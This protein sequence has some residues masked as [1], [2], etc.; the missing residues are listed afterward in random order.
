[1]EIV[2]KLNH[3]KFCYISNH[4]PSEKLLK[5]V[6]AFPKL[7]M[8]TLHGKMDD[9]L[10]KLLASKSSTSNPLKGLMLRPFS[11]FSIDAVE[12]FF[13]RATFVHK[14]SIVLKINATLSEVEEMFK[15]IDKFEVILLEQEETEVKMKLKKLDE[16]IFITFATL[17]NL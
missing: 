6:D 14:S 10:L 7:P 17:L 11:G 5:F 12:R 4:L 15:R 3:L 16:E 13:K 9:E 2:S 1:M 8:L